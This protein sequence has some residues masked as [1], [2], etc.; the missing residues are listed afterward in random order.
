MLFNSLIFVAFF[1]FV[2]CFYLL[3]KS[4][5]R[6]QNG[7]LLASSYVFYGYWDARFLLLL[8]F[9]T[10]IDY[11]VGQQI[12]SSQTVRSRRALLTLSLVSNLS[13]LGFFKYFNF[14]SEGTT[15]LLSVIGLNADPVTLNIILPVGISFY[16]FQTLSYS[17]DVYRGTISAEKNLL[18]FALFVSFFPQ[19][20][21]GPIER[22]STLLPQISA[23]RV[24]NVDQINAG[25]FLILWGY[26]KKLA[27]A[28]NLGELS[29]EVFESYTTYEGLD[30]LIG[31]LAFTIQIYSDFSGYSDIARGL[32]KLM[33][34]DLMLNFNLPFF[35]TSPSNFWARWHI[36]LSTWFRDYVYI[37]L[38]GNRS[39]TIKTYRNL[40]VTMILCGL[41]H[42]A[43]WNF[44][45]WGA[46]HGMILITYRIARPYFLRLPKWLI[47]NTWITSFLGMGMMVCLTTI[48][49]ILFRSSTMQQA[50]YMLTH[51]SLVSSSETF[52]L[53]YDLLFFS[54]PLLLVQIYQFITH[55]LLILTKLNPWLRISLYGCILAAIVIFSNRDRSDFIYFQF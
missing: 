18:N 21:A 15:H 34:F 43:A 35:A 51:I 27:I 2:Y 3:L 25:L 54:V 33:G 36:S 52:D 30:L 29:D 7:L 6:A 9:S 46:F 32:A 38:G 26:F 53:A 12:E 48:G 37:P 16:T 17:I 1:L 44:I 13:V 5:H 47:G 55:D 11:Y 40:A 41:W 23:P 42:G 28:D 39:G 4:N 50:L 22:A 20:V 19:L 8:L 14:F 49:W 45:V 31:A 24:L 10:G